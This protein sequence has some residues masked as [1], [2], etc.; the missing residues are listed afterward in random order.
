MNGSLSPRAR[1]ALDF[2]TVLGRWF[3][4]AA[5]VY[6]GVMK[7]LDPV[8]FL[9]MVRQY[10]LVQVPWLLNSIA[11]FL[12]WFEV[13]TG[14]LLLAGI[15]VR[16]TA[17]NLILMLIP[18]TALVL[19]RA[20]AMAA[21]QH[22]PFCAVSF[23]CGCGTGEVMICQKLVENC[24]LIFLSCWLLSGYGRQLSARFSLVSPV[25]DSPTPVSG[26]PATSECPG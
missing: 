23:D 7:L 20:L 17:L 3:V 14:S 24:A 11:A 16:G 25:S 4:G 10:E 8:Q 22:L 6:M 15:A 21:A 12:P 18:F 1:R 9:K 13:F 19:K 26:R 2:A 5:F